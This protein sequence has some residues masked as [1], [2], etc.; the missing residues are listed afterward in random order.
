M[1]AAV[2]DFGTFP[3]TLAEFQACGFIAQN[4]VEIV[5]GIIDAG[6]ASAHRAYRPSRGELATLLDI[7][8]NLIESVFIHPKR[9]KEVSKNVPKRKKKKSSNSH[10]AGKPKTV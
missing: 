8:E 9:L 6:N 3:K 4:Q 1:M 10:G 7:A 2:G 5:E